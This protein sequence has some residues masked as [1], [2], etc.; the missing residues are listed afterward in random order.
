MI[1]SPAL[2][3]PCHLSETGADKTQED[4]QEQG[5]EDSAVTGNAE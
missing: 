2:T 1:Q 3:A 4:Q 5:Q